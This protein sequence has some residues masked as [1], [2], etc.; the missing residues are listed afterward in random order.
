MPVE[1]LELTI[2]TTVRRAAAPERQVAVRLM[3]LDGAVPKPRQSDGLEVR[4][5]RT[6]S[7]VIA[8]LAGSGI[9]ADF[10]GE[11]VLSRTA[12][13]FPDVCKIPM[14]PAP[15]APVPYPNFAQTVPAGIAA[16][17][18]ALL[19]A[20]YRSARVVHRQDTGGTPLVAH[21]VTHTFQQRG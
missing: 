15:G 7:E 6:A 11:I 3:A 13:V 12:I 8:A 1:V 4:Y 5:L 18:R 10:D 16:V 2:K 20:G 17:S 21:E 9:G 14:P 19:G